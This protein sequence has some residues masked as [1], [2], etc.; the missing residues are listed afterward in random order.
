VWREEVPTR[1]RAV[2]ALDLPIERDSEGQPSHSALGE[3]PPRLH[4]HLAWHE[5]PRRRR[6]GTPAG[7]ARTADK[8]PG[9]T[10][11]DGI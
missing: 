1:L 7:T 10:R 9:D 3:K 6:T 2:E 8:P 4:E 5:S 11:P